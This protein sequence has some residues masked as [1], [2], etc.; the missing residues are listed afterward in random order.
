MPVFAYRGLTAAG[1]NVQ[2]VIDADS[3]RGARLRLR[4]DGIYPTEV[5]EERGR[6]PATAGLSLRRG[7][8]VSAADLALVSRQLSTL[9]AAGVPVVEALAAVG[10]QSDRP[11]LT[12][13]L[14]HVRDQVTQGTPLATA[15]AEF[16]TVFPELYVG[17]VRA[18]EAAGALDLVLERLA[19]YTE[20]QTRLTSRVRNALAY[21]VLMTVVSTGIVAFLLGFVVPRVTRIFADQKQTLPLLTRALLGVSSAIASSWWL[22]ALL[23]A[24]LVAWLVAARRRPQWRLWLDRKLLTLPLVGPLVTRV[25]VARFA[26]TLATLLGNGIPLLQ[27]LEVASG[28]AGNRAL[29]LAIDE[30]RA[31]IREGQSIAAP[32]RQSGLIPPLVTHMIAVG[33][34]SGE[35]EAMLGKVADGYEQEVESTLG[36]L[37]AVLEPVTIVVMGAIVLFIVLAILLPIFEIN[38]LVR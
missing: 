37:T 27:S 33:E 20:A 5:S 35:L 12:Q 3:A 6:E 21:P 25:A 8:R 9:I 14:S 13:V 18:G 22:I 19:T 4:R 31:A 10:E 2:G 36:T 30:A 16:P 17:M 34:R 29:A 38:A 24:G 28:V 26:R 7:P 23:L 1:R 11:A 32:L 15:L